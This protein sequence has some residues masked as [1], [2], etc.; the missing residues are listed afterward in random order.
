MKTLN[1]KFIAL[2]AFALLTLFCENANALTINFLQPTFSHKLNLYYNICS[3]TGPNVSCESQNIT[4][5]Y[6]QYY[7]AFTSYFHNKF[8]NITP[9]SPPYF[10]PNYQSD[11]SF[12]YVNSQNQTISC[13]NNNLA[14]ATLITVNLAETSC[15]ISR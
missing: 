10:M 8:A 2:S 14:A 11:I 5:L 12:N 9:A 3:G 7:P 6:P 4:G 15:S 13:D 1:F